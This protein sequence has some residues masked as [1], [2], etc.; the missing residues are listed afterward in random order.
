MSCDEYD[1]NISACSWDVDTP[2]GVAVLLATCD[3]SD[4]GSTWSV[5]FAPGSECTAPPESCQGYHDEGVCQ[6]DQGCRWLVPGCDPGEGA[7]LVQA[8]CYP[9]EA[10]TP[11]DAAACG[12]WGICTEVWYDPCHRSLCNACGGTANVCLHDQG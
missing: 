12:D 1:T 2:C 10:C 11:E 6:A 8:G 7:A 9:A 3:W 5:A 4:T